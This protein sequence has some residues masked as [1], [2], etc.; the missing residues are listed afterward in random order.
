MEGKDIEAW[1]TIIEETKD[2]STI[3]VPR[4]LGCGDAQYTTLMNSLVLAII[5]NSFI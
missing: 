1:R 5:Q 2:L 3:T 4:Y